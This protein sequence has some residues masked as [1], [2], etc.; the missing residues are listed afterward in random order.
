MILTIFYK[1]QRITGSDNP[2]EYTLPHINSN[3][4]TALVSKTGQFTDHFPEGGGLA[5][6]K[7]IVSPQKQKNPAAD[8]KISY[9][10]FHFIWLYC[11]G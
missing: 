8:K 7:K 9:Y 1:Q 2:V 3:L 4:A 10:I 5:S 6:R 11:Y